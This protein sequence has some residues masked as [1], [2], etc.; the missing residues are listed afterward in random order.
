MSKI[1]NPKFQIQNFKSKIQP[2]LSHRQLKF[3][4]KIWDFMSQRAWVRLK[5]D[6]TCSKNLTLCL[7]IGLNTQVPCLPGWFSPWLR[8]DV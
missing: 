3:H 7:P 1:S 4:K 8:M 5:S 2:Y 6:S